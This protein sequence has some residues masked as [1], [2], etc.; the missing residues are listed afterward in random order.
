[1]P[2]YRS[3]EEAQVRDAAVARLRELYPD[4]RVMMEVNSP[5][6]TRIDVLAVTPVT[7]IAAE[8]KSEKD[9]LS[10]I[11]KQ[12]EAQLDCA[13]FS[14]AVV[15]RK[16]LMEPHPGYFCMP[17]RMGETSWLW[18]Y[19][20]GTQ[21]WDLGH[22]YNHW[23][24]APWWAVELLWNP[25]KKE[26]LDRH[27]VKAN[28]RATGPDMTRLLRWHLTGEQLTRGICAMLREREV[29]EGDPPIKLQGL[30]Q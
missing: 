27:F 16:L 22:R 4:A 23:L 25:E 24:P 20:L 29:I 30:L 3:P 11:D 5:N 2:A 19:P 6:Y 13:H 21:R 7:I 8:I 15:H 17:D 10:R 9:T 28:S 12:L 18:P 1:M 14:I 26:L